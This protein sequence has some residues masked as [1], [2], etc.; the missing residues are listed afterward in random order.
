MTDR[1]PYPE[2]SRVEDLDLSRIHLH[3]AYLEGLRMTDAYLV[4]ADISG[5]VEGVRVN[6]VEIQPLVDAE[7]DRRHPERIKLRATDVDGL[8]EAWAMVGG[9]WAATTDRAARLP[10]DLQ[11]Q[12]VDGEW[13]FV[14]TLRHLVFATDCWLSRGVLLARHPY[15]PWGLP[16]SGVTEEW[17]RTVGVDISAT[18]N[19]S[20]VLPLREQRREAV[21]AT[22]ESL[23]D[24]ELAEVRS[25]PDEPG[26]P[27]GEHSVLQ[28]L[29]VLLN[30][31][32]WHHRYA[33]RDLDV[34]EA[35]PA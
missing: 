25:A 1:R 2:G 12:R 9:L 24:A 21:Q 10:E 11:L 20:E 17:A 19:L 7:L 23:S 15:H 33:V 14:E 31:E 18:P 35:M 22:L 16:W 26:H 3:G 27:S 5:D 32:W 13:S 6:G 29:H 4:G 8:R 34:L 28:C 30:E